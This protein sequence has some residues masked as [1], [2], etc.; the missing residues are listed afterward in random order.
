MVV[1]YTFFKRAGAENELF[2]NKY[3]I[4]PPVSQLQSDGLDN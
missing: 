4:F 2:K 1:G 3:N